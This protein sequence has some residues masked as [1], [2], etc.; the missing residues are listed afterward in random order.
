LSDMS[1]TC[2]NLMCKYKPKHL[3]EFLCSLCMG[4]MI[5]ATTV[6]ECMHHFCRSC[7]LLH[8]E[9]DAHCPSCGIL[10]N[11]FKLESALKLDHTLQL[12]IYKLIPT[13][14][15]EEILRRARFQVMNESPE[16]REKD[17]SN[18]YIR[19]LATHICSP[20][21][22][23]MFILEMKRPPRASITH[24]EGVLIQQPPASSFSEF[25]GSS[26]KRL[27]SAPAAVRIKQLRKMIASKFTVHYQQVTLWYADEILIDEYSLVDVFYIFLS[28]KKQI[29]H[30]Y[31]DI[32]GFE[33]QIQVMPE[34]TPEKQILA[35]IIR[36][37]PVDVVAEG[38]T[39]RK[40]AALHQVDTL[41]LML[42]TI[43]MIMT[44][45]T[46][47]IFKHRRLR[48]AITADVQLW[49]TTADVD[50][51]PDFL[52]L[53]VPYYDGIS[54]ENQSIL[55]RYKFDSNVNVF[56]EG[57]LE[58]KATFDSEIFFNILLPPI[59]FNAG[60]SLK[61]GHFFRNIGS[62]L[63]YAVCGTSLSVVVVGLVMYGFT[64]FVRLPFSL[65]ETFLFG[66]VISAT[67]PITVLAI[68]ND[69]KVDSDLFALVF[70][71]SALN[72]AVAIVLSQTIE[73][74]SP[75]PGSEA[76]LFDGRALLNSFG[77]FFGV[78]FG[79]MGIGSLV[80]CL[81]SLFMKFTKISQY[82]LLEATLFI[83]MSYLSFLISEAAH[84]TGIVSVLFCGI[85]QAH[86]TFN[87]LS[88]DS[89]MRTKQFFE[90]LTFLSENFIFTYIGVS[91]FTSQAHLFNIWFI[92]GAF[93]AIF[94]GRLIMIYPLTAI[95]NV[96]RRPPI[97]MKHQHMLF[98]A[99]L[100]GAMAFALAIRNTSSPQMRII[101]STTSLIV[102]FT[103]LFNGGLTVQIIEWLKIKCCDQSSA[104]LDQGML[105]PHSH[106]RWDK[107]LLPQKWYDFDNKFLKPLLTHAK[108]SLVETMPRWCLPIAKLFTTD[109]QYQQMHCI[110]PG[111]YIGAVNE[112]VDIRRLQDYFI[113]RVLTV[114]MFPPEIRYQSIT[115]LFV[116][117]KDLPEWNLM[118]D[119]DRCIEFIESAIRSKEN[120]L[121]H[122][123]EGISR[124]ATV[125][126]AYLMKNP[127][128][129]FMKQLNLFFKFGWQV[130]RNRPEY[131]LLAL[132]KWRKLHEGGLTK[133][134]ISEIISPD[135]D[136]F[137]PANS[138]NCPKTLYTCRKC[139]R[140]LYTQQSLLEHDKK[141]P[142][143]DC[144]DIDFILPVKWM[145]ESILQYEGKIN[146]P[147][148]GSKL[149]SFI[150]SGSRC[151]CTAW[152]S[153]AFM[154]HRC[155]RVYAF[156]HLIVLFADSLQAPYIYYL[157]ATY[158]YK[159]S[160]IA[161]LYAVGLFTNL[162][163]GLFLNYILQKF[164]R[165]VVCCVCCVL[166]S[167]SC[168]LK[169]SS[170]YYVLMWSRI[171]DGVAATMLLAPF[172]EWYLHEH[173][174]RYDFPK[175]WVAITFRYV[176]V[177]S[178]IF[179]IIAGYVAQFTEKVFETTVF[180]FLLCV[181][182]LSVA[183]IW[184]FC[185]WAPNRQEMRS[186]NHLWNDLTRAKRILLRRP[187]AL[188]VC[189]IQSL[190]EGSFYLFIFMWTPI[191]IQLNPDA[192]YSPSFGNIYACFMAST[193]LGTIL[194]RRLSTHLSISNLLSIATACSL[195]GMGFSVLVGYPGE[196]SG[197]KYKIL[198]LTLCLYQTGVGLYFPVMQRQQKDILPAEARPVLLALFRVPLN[199]IAIGALL[200]LHSHDYYG[201]WLL[202]VLCTALLAVCLLTTFL[203]TS[204]SKHSDVDYFV[205]QLK[206]DDEPPLLS[207]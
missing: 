12:L 122:C 171:F 195:A 35:E 120:I 141:K 113:S 99:G 129:G 127:N 172:Q 163:C 119:F 189:I 10:I 154:I 131:K 193:L 133:S 111:L 128:M 54:K 87:N 197:V 205:L 3:N 65:S 151:G 66:A 16:E 139:R 36:R 137:S 108:P 8:I 80:G 29:I 178:I 102:I 188:I 70:G 30:F 97:P 96:G 114:D 17:F 69:L 32:I 67:D 191:F 123:Q 125:V 117:A 14:Y 156:G 175:E 60:Y 7:I 23:V 31:Y 78:F 155:K 157:F 107:S 132:G 59:I 169:A 136:E 25:S 72:D 144:A 33:D 89:K 192:N 177:R 202:L 20:Y 84:M 4:Y 198:L 46:I 86:Y 166:T 126:A 92:L 22:R 181:P 48:G 109:L 51:P 148:C 174:N 160:D 159:E 34:L 88:S 201:N 165:R 82:P 167:G 121:V 124:S 158:G 73:R 146:C 44:V 90:V 179:S 105:S 6:V 15:K 118:D 85:C 164:E 190:Y 64:S 39:E 100:R 142:D 62:I 28:A 186:G 27:Y 19:D 110:E 182:I 184:I 112:A 93:I 18:D 143:D 76:L 52:R 79:S 21:E 74:H 176:F 204:L 130:D 149:G 11:K 203:L 13:V 153:P 150:W 45:L 187:N 40:L 43:L 38:I 1:K 180:P 91:L 194:Y 63:M 116:I 50:L 83:L 41:N 71:E 115:Y 199:I 98:F 37:L 147:K 196:T 49:N 161:L 81:A 206:S 2:E 152:I 134:T 168:F 140:C 104:E 170:D 56:K 68:F 101:Y 95:L 26:L 162:I 138:T 207:E 135:P 47:W 5:E 173:L 61:K 145:A 200:F 183:I 94:I 185:K 106:N 75:S 57:L 9:K 42:Y 24:R 55:L 103:V 58:E 77:H 53:S